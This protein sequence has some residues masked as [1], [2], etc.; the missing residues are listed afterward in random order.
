M[1]DTSHQNA[2]PGRFFEVRSGRSREAM[3]I[4]TLFFR[5][6]MKASSSVIRNGQIRVQEKYRIVKE[7]FRMPV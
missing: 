1:E 3:T 7:L 6:E 4:S 2:V 5:A